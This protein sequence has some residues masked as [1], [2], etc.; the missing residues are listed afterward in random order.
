MGTLVIT[1]KDKVFN[2]LI[3]TQVQSHVADKIVQDI[4]KYYPPDVPV[5]FVELW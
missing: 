1:Y 4:L 3:N 2:Y 5:D